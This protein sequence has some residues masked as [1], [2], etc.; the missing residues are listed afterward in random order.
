[1]VRD[2]NERFPVLIRKTWFGLNKKFRNKLKDLSITP[3]NYTIL[4]CLSEKGKGGICQET[5]AAMIFSNKNNTSSILKRMEKNGLISRKN[6]TS[7]QRKNIIQT[8]GKGIKVL[9]IAEIKAEEVRKGIIDSLSN[10]EQ[11]VICNA[12]HKIN[13]KL[14]TLK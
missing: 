8:T 2:D 3:V 4:R 1:M 6:S 14:K 5:L 10:G 12:L 7:D 9:Q 13:S 11:K